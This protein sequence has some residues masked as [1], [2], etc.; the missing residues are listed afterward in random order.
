VVIDP[1]ACFKITLFFILHLYLR[2][3]SSTQLPARLQA[4]GRTTPQPLEGDLF[5]PSPIVRR[6]YL[7]TSTAGILEGS[8][9]SPRRSPRKPSTLS[10]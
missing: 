2:A 6:L 5:L 10:D 9:E 3:G 4:R 1:S 8:R 7:L